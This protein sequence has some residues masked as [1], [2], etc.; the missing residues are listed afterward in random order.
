MQ[1]KANVSEMRSL[2]RL[3]LGRPMTSTTLR[4]FK[5]MRPRHHKHREK[6]KAVRRWRNYY[7][8]PQQENAL[9]IALC[10]F[11]CMSVSYVLI[12]AR[13]SARLVEYLE[14]RNLARVSPYEKGTI[15]WLYQCH[16]AY[17]QLCTTAVWSLLHSAVH[18]E[19]CMTGYSRITSPIPILSCIIAIIIIE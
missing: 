14:L 9:R 18:N 11:V 7:A 12:T 1:T 4:W 2:T 15:L 13:K 10:P 6:R 16:A 3:L 8:T 17:R 19:Y 5:L